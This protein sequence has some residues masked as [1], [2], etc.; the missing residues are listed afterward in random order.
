MK[1]NDKPNPWND[2]AMQALHKYL[3]H[4]IET[5]RISREKEVYYYTLLLEGRKEIHAALDHLGIK[6]RHAEPTGKE[7]EDYYNK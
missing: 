4:W 6:D 3:E 1:M 7:V 5:F 2:P